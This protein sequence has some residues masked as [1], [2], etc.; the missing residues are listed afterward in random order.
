ML[1]SPP[2][3]TLLVGKLCPRAGTPADWLRPGQDSRVVATAAVSFDTLSRDSFLSLKPPDDQA[4]L[5]NIAVDPS[6]R[7]QG[8]ARRMLAACETLAEERGF[9]RFYLHVRLGD[10]AARAL[11]D[12][13]GYVETGADSWLVKLRGR[14]P[15]ALLVKGFGKSGGTTPVSG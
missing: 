12:S 15:T 7:R 10:E 2:S 5:C 3:G 4:Y 6:F 14:T 1:S 9:E 13:S 8:V 11:Y